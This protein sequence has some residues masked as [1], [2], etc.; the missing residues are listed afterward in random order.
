MCSTTGRKAF[1]DSPAFVKQSRI[2]KRY[3]ILFPREASLPVGSSKKS[4]AMSIFSA[5]NIE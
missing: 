2:P 3:N 1:V 5:G 4:G